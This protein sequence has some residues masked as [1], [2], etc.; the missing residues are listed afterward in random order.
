MTTKARVRL[1]IAGKAT[2]RPTTPRPHAR[3]GVPHAPTHP[4]A[5]PGPV[6][7]GAHRF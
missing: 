5:R 7:A 3:L 6:E 1:V 4:H 2:Y